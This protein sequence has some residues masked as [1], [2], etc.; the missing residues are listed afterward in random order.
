MAFYNKQS[1]IIKQSY[2]NLDSNEKTVGKQQQGEKN[3]LRWLQGERF[4]FFFFANLVFIFTVVLH[5][6]LF[7]QLLVALKTALLPTIRYVL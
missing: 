3:S 6:V 7:L 1:M 2:R 5:S 4:F